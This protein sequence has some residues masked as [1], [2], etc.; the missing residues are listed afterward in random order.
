LWIGIVDE[1]KMNQENIDKGRVGFEVEISV[2][3]FHKRDSLT[4]K[5]FRLT[6]KI[7]DMIN[8]FCHEI[9]C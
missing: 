6:S 1:V 7:L 4:E 2:K 9:I 5:V 8:C 3:L